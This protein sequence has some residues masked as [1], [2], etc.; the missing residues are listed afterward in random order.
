[1]LSNHPERYIDDIGNLHHPTLGPKTRSAAQLVSN[2]TP[3]VKELS[4]RNCTVHGRS[5]SSK[6]ARDGTIEELSCALAAK[7][8]A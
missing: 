4:R 8:A 2:D 7:P 1:M 3:V 5:R 6:L